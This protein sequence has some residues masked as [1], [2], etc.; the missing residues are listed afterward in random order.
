MSERARPITD[1]LGFG[2]KHMVV[3]TVVAV[4]LARVLLTGIRI[5]DPQYV[6]VSQNWGP[7]KRAELYSPLQCVLV[8][9]HIFLGVAPMTHTF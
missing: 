1:S 9:F 8:V 4:V 5:S 3:I 2:A 6:G 7:H